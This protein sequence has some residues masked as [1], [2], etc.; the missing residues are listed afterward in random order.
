MLEHGADV[1]VIQEILGHAELRTTEI[2][3]LHARQHRPS[4]SG[5]RPHAPGREARASGAAE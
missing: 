4:Q 5:A 2:Y 1:R 3:T